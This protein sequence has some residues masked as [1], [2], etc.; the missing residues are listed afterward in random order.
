LYMHP[1]KLLYTNELGLFSPISFKW[2]WTHFPNSR[3]LQ[4]AHCCIRQMNAFAW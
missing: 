2:I 4:F 3:D 1:I